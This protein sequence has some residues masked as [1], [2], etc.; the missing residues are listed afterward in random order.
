MKLRNTYIAL[1]FF[2]SAHAYA[3][4]QNDVSIYSA[5]RNISSA[6]LPDL[7]GVDD[8]QNALSKSH[9]ANSHLS[10][11]EKRAATSPRQISLSEL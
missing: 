2:V 8:S 6:G 4:L 5:E 1:Y 7:S 9:I 3:A 10:D 11:N